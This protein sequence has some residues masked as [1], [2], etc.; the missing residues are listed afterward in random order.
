MILLLQC[1]SMVELANNLPLS[2][3]D[4][5]SR[6]AIASSN[7]CSW[8]C[9]DNHF[10]LQFSNNG[11]KEL[12][13][14]LSPSYSTFDRERPQDRQVNSLLA[15]SLPFQFHAYL[16]LTVPSPPASRK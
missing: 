5:S 3:S 15:V 4:A 14:S 11:F 16:D 7:D 8:S 9:K 13:A 12:Q 10:A 2:L 1:F 6:L